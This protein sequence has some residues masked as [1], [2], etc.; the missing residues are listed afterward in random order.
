M[1]LTLRRVILFT[2]RM[3]EMTAFYRDVIGLRLVTEEPK[4]KDFDASGMR[5]SL[6]AGE[7]AIGKTKLAFYTD[8]VRGARAELVKRGAKMRDVISSDN[9]DLCDGT[10]PDGNAFQLSNRS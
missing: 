10:D 6:H 1:K 8:D 2:R 5:L 7:S 4:W 9:L 3:D